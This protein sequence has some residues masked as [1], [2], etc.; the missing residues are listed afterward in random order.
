MAKPWNRRGFLGALGASALAVVFD[1][2][3]AGLRRSKAE[4]RRA[5]VVAWKR[6][7]RGRH[8]S[9]AAKAHNANHIYVSF[10]AA[11]ADRAHP[12][13][14][15]RPVP[16]TI[17]AALFAALFADGKQS[18]DLRHDLHTLGDFA[19]LRNCLS[20]PGAEIEKS[21]LPH[22]LTGDTTV[23]LRDVAASQRAFTPL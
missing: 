4:T 21:C 15:S 5:G 3:F 7:G 12:G 10:Q 11:A 6:S 23:D 17:N 13:D 8:V 1:W 18:V 16:V 20:G 22:D 19:G 2:T 9:N 14:K